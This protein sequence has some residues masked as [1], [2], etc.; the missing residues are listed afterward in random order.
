MAMS[1]QGGTAD[2]RQIRLQCCQ[3]TATPSHALKRIR[4]SP[5]DPEQSA[6][7]F[8]C[9]RIGPFQEHEKVMIIRSNF[10]Q[11][12]NLHRK[13][14]SKTQHADLAMPLTADTA[15]DEAMGS[16]KLAH[17]Q[18]LAWPCSRWSNVATLPPWPHLCAAALALAAITESKA[19]MSCCTRFEKRHTVTL[20]RFGHV[21]RSESARDACTCRQAELAQ[22]VIA[23]V[24]S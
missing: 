4:A 16:F 2:E 24:G 18:H 3:L 7:G 12:C 20:W 15:H 21:H 6:C 19:L 9:Y 23:R 13:R 5:Q 10:V 22:S 14:L 1:W 11:L 17:Q 8:Q